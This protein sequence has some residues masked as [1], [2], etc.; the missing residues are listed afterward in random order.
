MMSRCRGCRYAS[1]SAIGELFCRKLKTALE[2][3]Y[4]EKFHSERCGEK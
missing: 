3:G 4:A 1:V 2:N